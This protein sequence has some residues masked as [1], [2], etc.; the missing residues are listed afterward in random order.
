MNN[1]NEIIN[2]YNDYFKRR[3]D[4]KMEHVKLFFFHIMLDDFGNTYKIIKKE[5]QERI[6]FK[7][8]RTKN[9]K[10]IIE[11][12]SINIRYRLLID[13]ESEAKIFYIMTA[14]LLLC[15]ESIIRDFSNEFKKF[16]KD[17]SIVEK[18][19]YES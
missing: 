6:D 13:T 19:K 3:N 11:S 18:I 15:D 7:L 14:V 12:E 16:F 2:D 10:Y 4:N 9:N 17:N 5:Y 1:I 8:Y